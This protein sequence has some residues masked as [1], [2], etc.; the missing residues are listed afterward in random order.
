MTLNAFAF[1][2]SY[3]VCSPVDTSTKP[4]WISLIQG[5][6]G[7]N[8]DFVEGQELLLKER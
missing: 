3:L 5:M 2:G 7:G 6:S 4:G 1:T 8:Q